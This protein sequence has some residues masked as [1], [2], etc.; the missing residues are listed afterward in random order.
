MRADL[1]ISSQEHYQIK[2]NQRSAI[3]KTLYRHALEREY[4]EPHREKE[5]KNGTDKRE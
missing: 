4:R 2:N 3:G 5:H 1:E